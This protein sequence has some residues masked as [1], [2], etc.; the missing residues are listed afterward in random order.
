VTVVPQQALALFN[1]PLALDQSRRL[2]GQLT[3]ERNESFVTA[4]F[5][6]VLGRPPT[7]AE[8]V[9][10]RAFLTEQEALLTS[11]AR[12]NVMESGPVS[13]IPPASDPKQRAR[14]NLVHTLLNHTDFVT[15]R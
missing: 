1:S 9:R 8:A 15:I 13:R 10:C 12:A 11:L 7:T 4:A 2:A 14:E 5:L 6:R 3:K